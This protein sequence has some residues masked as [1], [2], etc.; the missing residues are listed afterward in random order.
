VTVKVI[1]GRYVESVWAVFQMPLEHMLDLM[2]FQPQ[3]RN[4]VA[5]RTLFWSSP[6][7]FKEMLGTRTRFGSLKRL[8]KNPG[9]ALQ[10]WIASE[11][12]QVLKVKLKFV[13]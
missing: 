3:I 10:S 13:L 7:F 4:T 12:K 2:F 8:K 1:L 5:C 9:V 11:L 6:G